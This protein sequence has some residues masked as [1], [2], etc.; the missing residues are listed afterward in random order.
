MKDCIF[1]GPML[2]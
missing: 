2:L 1:S